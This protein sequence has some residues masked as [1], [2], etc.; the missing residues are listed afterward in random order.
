MKRPRS[1]SFYV[2]VWTAGGIAAAMALYGVFQYFSL[3]DQTV[4]G[5]LFR[6]LWH[7]VALGFVIWGVCWF[8][9]RRT[10]VR[11]VR[12]IQRHLYGV[13]TGHVENLRLDTP[14]REIG[15]MVEG[16]NLMVRRMR[17]QGHAR[18]P[19]DLLVRTEALR[20]LVY[21]LLTEDPAAASPLLDEIAHLE[22]SVLAS[23][24]PELDAEPERTP[25]ER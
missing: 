12:A 15:S 4:G 8:G 20:N 6:H 17:G 9:F 13:A 5:L 1:L 23:V 2:A 14:V 22:S 18:G 7:V 16:V 10:L 11:P 3:P 21:S 24:S 25:T 19:E